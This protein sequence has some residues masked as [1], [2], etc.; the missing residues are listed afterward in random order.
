MAWRFRFDIATGLKVLAFLLSSG[1]F[2]FSV[3][4]VWT[5]CSVPVELE[6]R[7]GTVWIYALAKRAGVDIYDS[8]RL[9]FV[10]MNHGP[11]DAIL[12]GWLA[13]L[14]PTLPGCMVTRCFVFLLPFFLLGSAYFVFRRSL[15]EALL[16]AAALHLFLVKLTAMLLVGRSDATALCGLAICA[17]F[18]HAL[19]V[20]R[21]REWSN[22]RYVAQQLLLGASSAVVFLTSWRTIPTL[23]MLH[24]VVFAKQLAESTSRRFRCL[25]YA[26]ALSITGFALVWVPT[27]LFEL[28]GNSRL[29]YQRFFGFFSQKSGW[30]S[31]PGPKFRLFP[32]ELIQSRQG[33]LLLLAGLTLVALFRLRRERAQLI[34]WLLLLPLGWLA[35]SYGFYINQGGGGL[36]YFC[37][38]F[39][40]VWFLVL[41]ALRQ[42]SKWRPLAQL[43]VAGLIVGL[44]PWQGLLDQRRQLADVRTEAR[45]FL[46]DVASLT[47]GQFVFGED[48]HL[49]KS[50]YCD[51]VGDTCDT[52]DAIA[53]SR[54]Y[55]ENLTRTYLS[56][57]NTL[58]SD[59]PPFIIAAMLDQGT[60][61]GTTT[62]HLTDLLKRSYTLVLQGPANL[63][64]DGG[65]AIALYERKAE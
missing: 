56:Y 21:H 45:T 12:K 22:R 15:T 29:Y 26:I 58:L 34:A 30:G 36:Q 60:L 61:I 37:P 43:V 5:A 50:E 10:N 53:S 17:A 64:A 2:A 47:G 44:L 16:A 59:P 32:A 19:L 63:V 48:A 28:H 23:A 1:L 8:N 31:F 4:Y 3:W 6:I 39:F 20:K 51:E 40:S 65:G 33:L 18:A 46:K 62:P 35:Y 42:K 14:A 38:F 11:M 54:Y 13:T 7:E 41:H 9:A 52:V 49:F 57:M 24:L 55:G 25:I 27:F